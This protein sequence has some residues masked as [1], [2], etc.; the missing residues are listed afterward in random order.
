M[1]PCSW[2]S[3]LPED[4]DTL[5]WPDALIKACSDEFDYAMRLKTGECFRFRKAKAINNEWVHLDGVRL[6]QVGCMVEED[7]PNCLFE[8]GVDV[9]VTSIVWVADAPMGS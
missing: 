7:N 2:R 4:E 1:P 6:W 3:G 5:W 8:R 9:H